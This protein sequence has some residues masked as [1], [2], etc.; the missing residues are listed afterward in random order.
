MAQ[1]RGSKKVSAPVSNKGGRKRNN[2]QPTQKTPM[3]RVLVIGPTGKRRL[4]WRP[5]S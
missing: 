2:N 1:K 3:Q 5:W 4:E